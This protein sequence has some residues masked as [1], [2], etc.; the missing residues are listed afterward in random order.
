MI[1][2]SASVSTSTVR[3][4]A[5][6][7][8]GALLVGAPLLTACGTPKQGAAAVVGDDQISV[9]SLQHKVEQ[10]RDAQNE[11]NHGAPAPEPERLPS[12][13]LYGMVLSRVTDQA[14][15]DEGI[16][17][18]RRELQDFRER[19]ESMAGGADRLRAVLLQQNAIAPEEIDSFFRTELGLRKLAAAQGVQLGT[20]EGNAKINALLRETA[21]SMG[22]TV[23][24]RYGKW[25]PDQLT[26]DRTT[27][28]WLPGPAENR[29]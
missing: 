19:N 11:A 28:P 26:I 20:P 13:T 16:E 27:E 10:V 14:L 17:V 6:L 24:P 2:R 21:D 29:A 8:A 18:T 15:E 7:A 1:R 4:T 22:I 3:R 25:N 12:I 23:N 5:L 9:S